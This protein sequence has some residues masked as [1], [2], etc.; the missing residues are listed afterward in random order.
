[1]VLHLHEKAQTSTLILTKCSLRKLESF[2]FNTKFCKIQSGMLL[3]SILYNPIDLGK[4]DTH[5]AFSLKLLK[6]INFGNH[7]NAWWMDLLDIKI[8]PWTSNIPLS[9]SLLSAQWD[10]ISITTFFSDKDSHLLGSRLRFSLILKNQY[11]ICISK[12]LHS[13][14]T[15]KIC[16]YNTDGVIWGKNLQVPKLIRKTKQVM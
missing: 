1:M 6:A 14:D 4:L 16:R 2:Q 8:S 5:R 10:I 9:P 13:A 3:K 15:Q 11:K 12:M 7:L